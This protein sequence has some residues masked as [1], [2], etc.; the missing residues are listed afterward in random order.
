MYSYYILQ[1]IEEDKGSDCHVFRKWGRVGNDKIGGSK[2]E[3]MPKFDA[4]SEFKRLFFEKT[5]NPWEAWEQKTIQK[6]PGRFF[7]LEIV[8]YLVLVLIYLFDVSHF[9]SSVRHSTD[10]CFKHLI[11]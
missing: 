1:I 9:H 11:L 4:I 7:P 5:G 10:G 2:L 6:Q 8:L 3:E